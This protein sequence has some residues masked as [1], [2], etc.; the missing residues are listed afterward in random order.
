MGTQAVIWLDG[1]ALCVTPE[2]WN[3]LRCTVPDWL[4]LDCEKWS[5]S[6]VTHSV[7]R[8]AGGRRGLLTRRREDSLLRWLWRGLRRRPLV[9]PELREAG[10]L[11]RRQRHGVAGPRLLAFGQRQPRPWRI[12]SFLLTEIEAADGRRVA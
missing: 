12:E 3:E 6:R 10:A 5:D 8:L 4:R 1:E 9:S 2:F 7:V 11:F